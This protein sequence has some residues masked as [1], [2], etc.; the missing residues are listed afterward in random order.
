MAPLIESMPRPRPPHLHREPLKR[1]EARWYVRVGHGPRIRIRERYGTPE[2]EEAYVAALRGE[3]SRR[4]I[5]L[6]SEND[7]GAINA[8]AKTFGRFADKANVAIEAVHHTRKLGGAAATIEDSRGASAWVSAA[9]DV[10]VLNRMTKEEGEKAGIDAGKERLYFRADSDGNLAPASAT[11]WFSLI[12][13]ALGNSS[14]TGMD[15]Q[16]YVGVVIPWDWPDAFADVTVADLKGGAGGS[17][18]RPL[19]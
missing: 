15:D 10:R 16:D 14:H 5:Q 4:S 3:G 7:N 11:G 12:S 1:G 2:F 13:V 8:V 18:R 19:A 17:R 9:R 6:V